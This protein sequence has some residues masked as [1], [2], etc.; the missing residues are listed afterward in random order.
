MEINFSELTTSSA[1][2]V[3]LS[4]FKNHCFDNLGSIIASVLSECPT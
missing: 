4:I 1:G 2:F 3:N